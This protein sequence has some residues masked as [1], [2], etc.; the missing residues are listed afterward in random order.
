MMNID[1]K[2]FN[3]ILANQLQQHIKKLIHQD[4]VGFVPGMQVLQHMRVLKCNSPHKQN[5]RL[6]PHDYLNTCREGLP[7]NSTAFMPKTLKKLGI[8][9]TYLKIIKAIYNKPTAN[10]IEWAKTGSITFEIWH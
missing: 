10:I 4:Q 3:K 7:Q 6:K 2:I 9:G 5:Q 8:N 1:A